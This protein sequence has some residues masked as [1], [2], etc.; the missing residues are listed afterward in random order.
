[1]TGPISGARWRR[2]VFEWLAVL[3]IAVLLAV[4]VR[5]YVAQMFSI[6]SG[7]MLPTL[8]IGDRIMV[9]KVTFHLH[10]VR[11]GDIVVFTRPP[12]EQASYA[13]LVKRVVGLPGET[14]SSVDGRVRIDGRP[15]VEPWL[16]T[17]QP[18]TTPSRLPDG[19]SLNHPFTVPA[20]EYFVMGDNRTDSEDSRYFGPIPGKLIVGTMA[21]KVWP[22]D[23]V[24]WLLILTTVTAG[25]L[26]AVLA[27]LAALRGARPSTQEGDQ[28]HEGHAG[29]D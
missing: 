6:P 15:L 16:A 5:N 17:P 25:V 7:S 1:M 14:V 4:C 27:A 10:G 21:I 22:L 11:R 19:F 8:Q 3:G 28:R 13:D 18:V 12:L 2:R 24:M 9:D 20:G 26:V 29:S 23:A